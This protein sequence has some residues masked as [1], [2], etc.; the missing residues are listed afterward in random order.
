MRCD[1]LQLIWKIKSVVHAAATIELCISPLHALACASCGCSL[2]SNWEMLGSSSAGL[3]MDIRYDYLNEDQLR[4]GTGTISP[5]AASQLVNG[6]G[7][8]EVEKF[9]RNS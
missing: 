6:E 2:S 1:F 9:T 7:S 3:R 5:V 8:Q 4:P